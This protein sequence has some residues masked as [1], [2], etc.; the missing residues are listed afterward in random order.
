METCPMSD[1]NR[2]AIAAI[3]E[4]AMPS[5]RRPTTAWKEVIPMRKTGS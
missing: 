5:G 4:A 1:A 3:S 2:I